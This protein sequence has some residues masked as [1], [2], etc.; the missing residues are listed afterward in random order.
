MGSASD[1][2]LQGD[3]LVVGVEPVIWTLVPTATPPVTGVVEVVPS[4]AT[5]SGALEVIVPSTGQAGSGRR[6]LGPRRRGLAVNRR[7]P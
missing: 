2:P 4:S 3:D 1:R 7:Q 6:T 5:T